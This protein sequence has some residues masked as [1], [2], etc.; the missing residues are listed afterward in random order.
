[1]TRAL[2]LLREEFEIALALLGATSPDR[3]HRGYLAGAPP[4]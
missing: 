1:V 4:R 3:L 2:D